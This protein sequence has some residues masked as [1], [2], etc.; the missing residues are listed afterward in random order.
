MHAPV[1]VAEH[2]RDHLRRNPDGGEHDGHDYQDWRMAPV[3]K[4]RFV[5]EPALAPAAFV[6]LGGFQVRVLPQ[7]VPYDPARFALLVGTFDLRPAE[8][9]RPGMRR[10]L[11]AT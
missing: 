8:R 1:A 6:R 9:S 4:P 3:L 5:G 2:Q 10:A 7:A 11:F